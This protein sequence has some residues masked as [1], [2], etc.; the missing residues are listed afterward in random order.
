MEAIMQ[1]IQLQNGSYA[2]KSI[3][4]STLNTILGQ[5][6]TRAEAEEWMM[7]HTVLSRAGSGLIHP[8]DGQ[9]VA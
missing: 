5:F 7:R 9:A 1:V 3:G 2:V 8:G 6:A 4:G